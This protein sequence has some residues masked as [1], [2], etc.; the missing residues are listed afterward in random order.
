MER[1]KLQIKNGTK[2]MKRCEEGKRREERGKMDGSVEI[3][4]R[5]KMTNPWINMDSGQGEGRRR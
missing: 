5:Y 1:E 4:I 3:T 2:Q